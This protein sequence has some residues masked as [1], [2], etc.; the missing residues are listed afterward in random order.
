MK[1]VL[2]RLGPGDTDYE[3][4]FGVIVAP[5]LGAAALL[6]AVLPDALLPKCMLHVSLGIPCPTCGACRALRLLA[7][8]RFADAWI[9]Q[10]LIVTLLAAGALYCAYSSVVVFGKRARL[11]PVHV[12]RREKKVMFFVAVGLAVA[13][14][15][16]LFLRAV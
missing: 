5:I 6:V 10:P 9:L 2:R 16:Y 15:A 3:L 7:G 1:L 12:S 4:L 13:N 11:R 8:G 14:W